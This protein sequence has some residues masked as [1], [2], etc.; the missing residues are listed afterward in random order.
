[1]NNVTMCAIGTVHSSRKDTTD[2]NWG[3]IIAEIVL[4]PL[5][6]QPDALA[7]LSE[8]SHVEIVYFF[9]L[10]AENEVETGARHPRERKDWPCVGIFAQRGKA[11]PNRIGVS[12][13]RIL[14]VQG[15]TLKVAAL[16]AI[17]G[18]PVL[19]IKP[20]MVEFSPLEKTH[21]PLWATELMQDYY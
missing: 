5:K 16:D 11:R 15:L 3:N 14:D 20:W 6:F 21:Q 7:G 10:V 19:D 1:V 12:R 8:F 9:H 2:D 4:D 18:T 13:C 17:E